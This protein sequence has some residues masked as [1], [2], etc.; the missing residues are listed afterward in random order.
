MV[1]FTKNVNYQLRLWSNFYALH[2]LQL[3]LVRYLK[4]ISVI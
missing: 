1:L 3:V 4:A 2:L